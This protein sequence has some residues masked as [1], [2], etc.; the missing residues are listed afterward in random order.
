MPFL[1]IG[2]LPTPFSPASVPLPPETGGRWHTSLRVGGWGGVPFPTRGIHYGT[3]YMYVLC[4][5]KWSTFFLFFIFFFFLK[6]WW[7]DATLF[8]YFILYIHTF[9]FNHIHTIHLSIA[10]RRGLSPSPH[11]LQTQWEKPP[12]GAEPRIELGPAYWATP[13]H[14]NWATPLFCRRLHLLH[15]H[16][17]SY[18]RL[19]VH[20]IYISLSL[21]LLCVACLR[22]L[23]GE[24]SVETKSDIKERWLLSL[25][26]FL[27]QGFSSN[28]S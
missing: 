20:H 3:L 23:T 21:P 18:C 26:F 9:T 1:G 7:Q 8:V 6:V 5:P 28:F 27:L 22:K 24:W 19:Y 2:T 15:P 16:P 14:T 11:R 10:I 17:P 25:F 12:C 13:H 4:E